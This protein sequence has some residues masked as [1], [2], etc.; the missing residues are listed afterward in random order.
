MLLAGIYGGLV[1]FLIHRA[2]GRSDGNIWSS[3][4]VGVGASFLVPLFLNMISSDLTTQIVGTPEKSGDPLK[5]LVFAGFCLIAA[6]SSSA[7]I[8]IMTDQVLQLAKEAKRDATEAKKETQEIARGVQD[9]EVKL[10]NLAIDV[11][12]VKQIVPEQAEAREAPANP[13]VS[14]ELQQ[15]A[16]DYNRANDIKDEDERV[17]GK[18][19]AADAMVSAALKSNTDR[20][21][22]ASKADE[23]SLVALARIVHWDPQGGDLQRLVTA[24]PKVKSTFAMIEFLRAFARLFFERLVTETDK[25]SVEKVFRA[26]LAQDSSPYLAKRVEETRVAIDR[27]LRTGT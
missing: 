3:C 4:C 17:R 18:R 24:S 6:I 12:G 21:A 9:Q 27:R 22:L 25:A 13:T 23:G 20:A 26:F 11:R 7:F 5:A 10:D 15:L 19:K 16:D 14:A 1:N 2:D 8:R